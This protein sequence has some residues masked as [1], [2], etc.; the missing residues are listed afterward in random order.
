MEVLQNEKK[1]V[2]FITILS[3]II[4]LAVAI[5]IFM[6]FR[7]DL[8]NDF[9]YFLPHLNGVINSATS[10]ILILGLIFI[11]NR[12]IEYHRASMMAAFILGSI[13]LVSYIIYHASAES[14]SFGGEGW[15]KSVYYFILISHILLAAIVVPLVLFA[16]YYALKGDFVRHKK[17]VKYTFLIWL[18]VSISGVV[19]YLTIMQY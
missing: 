8:G 9:I 2:R 6:P 16:F 14:T 1:S 4:P 18:Y 11:K 12:Q 10:L 19:V 7:L 13:F 3:V 15:V 5:L 17:V